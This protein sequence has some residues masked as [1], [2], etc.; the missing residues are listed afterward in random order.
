MPLKTIKLNS[1]RKN[2]NYKNRKLNNI[3][4]LGYIGFN[5]YKNGIKRLSPSPKK[6]NNLNVDKGKLINKNLFAQILKKSISQNTYNQNVNNNN[7]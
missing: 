1:I 7:K 5:N 3:I 2:C 6:I 4:G